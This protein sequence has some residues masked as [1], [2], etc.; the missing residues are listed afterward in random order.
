MYGI[1]KLD[2]LQCQDKLNEQKEYLLSQG[3]VNSLGECK[4]LLDCSMSANFS[5]KYYAEISNR[6]N[7]LSSFSLL[8]QQVPV[9]LTITLNGC[10]RNAMHGDYS[11]FKPIDYKY[12]PDE[13]KYKAKNNACLTIPDLVAILNYQWHSF[14]KRYNSK[15][16]GVERSYIRCFEPHKKDGVP[17]IHA[18][19]YVPS[20][21]L[22]YMK[23]IY[24][25]LFN[26]PQNLKTN[27]IT[28]EQER[29]GEMNGFQTSINN[30]SGYVMK[31][32]Q[33]TFINLNETEELDELSAWYVKHKVRRFLSSR[34]KVPLWVYRKINF[35]SSMRDFYHLNDFKYDDENILEWDYLSKYIYI[36]LP[37]RD[38]KIIYDNGR[39]E[40]YIAG[41]LM[42]SYDKGNP[43]KN[44]DKSY[45]LDGKC[46]KSIDLTF[47][48]CAKEAERFRFINAL[49]NGEIKKPVT[50]MR[51]YELYNY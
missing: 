27:A 28:P 44:I 51:D 31:Y 30:P 7:T 29:N 3:Y 12:L 47:E 23:K 13:V 17:H 24:T 41:R 21:T 15:F 39:L 5:K 43:P 26:A 45:R 8:F 38:E 48:R 46:P 14:I 37:R 1:D 6:V 25:D 34:S 16:K 50:R 49:K 18:L 19:F 36:Y 40:H 9:F 33:K 10:F 32:I 22:E 11:K 35:I 42:N 2:L 20:H 4:T